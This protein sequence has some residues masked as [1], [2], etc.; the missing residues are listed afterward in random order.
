MRYRI[1]L[2]CFILFG[3]SCQT[4]T[5]PIVKVTNERVVVNVREASNQPV[6]GIDVTMSN[7]TTNEYYAGAKTDPNGDWIQTVSVPTSGRAYKLQIGDPLNTQNRYGVTYDSVFLR[8]TD[9]TIYKRIH[10]VQLLQCNGVSSE[11]SASLNV[12]FDSTRITDTAESPWITTNGCT[13][14][15][16]WAQAP[17]PGVTLQFAMKSG[18]NWTILASPPA[19]L[20]STD[21][22]RITAF[23]APALGADRSD[24]GSVTASIAT[25]PAS[26]YTFDIFST[27]HAHCKSCQCPGSD[28]TPMFNDGKQPN[29]VC[30]GKDSIF[31][32]STN[33]IA[34]TSKDASC[35]YIF[36][37]ESDFADPTELQAS[38]SQSVVSAGQK[39]QSILLHFSPLTGPRKYDE[40]AVYK[41]TIRSSDGTIT[42]CSQK[43]RLHVQV[44]SVGPVCEVDAVDLLKGENFNGKTYNLS[45]CVD[46]T[47][48]STTITLKNTGDCPLLTPIT[49]N[50]SG[51]NKDLF[52]ASPS[53]VSFI[54]AHDSAHVKLTFKP[55]T[56]DVWP[57][58]NTCDPAMTDFPVTLNI[59][60]CNPQTFNLT[61]YAN[62][63]C[64]RDITMGVSD[65]GKSKVGLE[66][67]TSNDAV[68]T[69]DSLH[70]KSW[71][72][73]F[74]KITATAGGNGTAILQSAASASGRYYCY[75][76]DPGQCAYV[77]GE[78]ICDNPKCCYV[79][80]N[81]CSFLNT[82]S[83]IAIQAHHYYLFHYYHSGLGGGSAE[84]CGLIHVD[85]IIHDNTSNK[86]FVN[87]EFCFPIQ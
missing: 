18:N 30:I 42:Q 62:P 51:P 36:S 9:T 39:M 38:L 22:L 23:Y 57:S 59:Q 21:T 83:Q 3:V 68:T 53:V 32:F 31:A 11:D 43:L 75:F 6:P 79:N 61:A 7:D 72:L 24:V 73:Y 16:S 80:N 37:L 28:W 5:Q 26:T 19:Q 17:P 20:R 78:Q 8:C 13:L 47:D 64:H 25:T 67:D 15:L 34:N 40:T 48:H 65:S 29:K 71:T 74:T 33:G 35:Q 87:I 44:E 63:N 45:Q 46:Q 1:A 84:R 54:D 77:P 60:N 41:I 2:I 49:I 58:G 70:I 12:C 82:Q 10:R 50:F 56:K 81:A 69:S 52:E 86:D 55:T 66:I 85:D 76:T 4:P 14:D 27:T